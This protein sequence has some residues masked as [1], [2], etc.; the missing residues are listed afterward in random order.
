M[1]SQSPGL[2]DH[3]H[4]AKLLWA[5]HAPSVGYP[6][7]VRPI[8]KPIRGTAFF[9]GGYGL[10]NPNPDSTLPRF[11]LGGTMILGHDFHSEAGY[12]ASFE[13]GSEKETQ[14]TWRN[15]L[16]LLAAAGIALRNCFFTNVFMGL[17]EG[18]ATTGRFPGAI[19]PDFV[20]HC[21]R[22]LV[23]QLQVQRPSLVLTL[24]IYAPDML[25]SASRSPELAPWAR[26]KGLRH[27]DQAGPVRVG[28]TF[29][30]DLPGFHTVV[31]ALTHPSMRHASVRYRRYRDLCGAPAELLMLRD[32]LA[33]LRREDT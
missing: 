26:G 11:P 24:G 29:P 5:E 19:D 32:A 21:S 12:K 2:T 22:F 20:A 27:L 1:L 23:R 25:A 6:P 33:K 8:P 3:M 18:I 9:P 16:E 13:R 31:V 14:P 15:L 10:W 17:R 30:E 28:V 7:G 4:P